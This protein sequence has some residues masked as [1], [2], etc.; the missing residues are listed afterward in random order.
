MSEIKKKSLRSATLGKDLV[1]DT[2]EKEDGYGGVIQI[3]KHDSLESVIHNDTSAI[4]DY[5]FESSAI[6]H[7]VVQC[8]MTDKQNRRVIGIGESIP[9]TLEND[10][11]QNY[12]SLIASQRAFDRAAIRYLNLP[13]KVFSNLE[14][15]I[16]GDCLD[17]VE[18]PARNESGIIST[19]CDDDDDSTMFVS[20]SN[21]N[22]VVV[23]DDMAGIV[24]DDEAVAGI[25]DV[26]TTVSD[27]DELPFNDEPTEDY[28]S[29]VISMKGKY[30]GKNKTVAEIYEIDASWMNWIADNFKP[31]NNPVAE[32]DVAAIC[33]YVA[34]KRAK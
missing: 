20:D 33:A 27:S 25:P 2:Y 13:G 18:P 7:T 23:D 4:Y 12:P 9:A 5:R 28:G 29:H 14:I 10:I 32:K 34:Q 21:N 8:I 17:V 31:K 16:V 1:F 15:T 3:I 22:D 19:I 26:D 6:D 30:A 24:M 11:A